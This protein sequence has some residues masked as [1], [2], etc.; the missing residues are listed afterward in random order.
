[1]IRVSVRCVSELSLARAPSCALTWLC[2]RGCSNQHGHEERRAGH[3]RGESGERERVEGGLSA[4]LRVC[5]AGTVVRCKAQGR[6]SSTNG[7]EWGRAEE[8]RCVTQQARTER[9]KQP[10]PNNSDRS[11]RVCSFS[12]DATSDDVTMSLRVLMSLSTNTVV[13]QILA[14]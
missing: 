13:S 3:G 14:T 2:H 5:D 9:S 7:V 12:A 8:A 10:S 4:E 1:M 11:C 6:W